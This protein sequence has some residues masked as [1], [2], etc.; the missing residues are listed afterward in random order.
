MLEAIM[1]VEPTMLKTP[2]ENKPRKP[3]EAYPITRRHTVAPKKEV[4]GIVA[5]AQSVRRMTPFGNI[6]HAG[7]ISLPTNA[8][9]RATASGKIF[10]IL[11]RVAW[12]M[13]K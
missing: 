1:D 12:E 11:T 10:D 7:T 9:A 3:L 2:I 5:I 8:V 6:V 13:Q 4:G